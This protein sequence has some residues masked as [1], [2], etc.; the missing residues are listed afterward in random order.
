MKRLSK[1]IIE[2]VVLTVF[3]VAI[4]SNRPSNDVAIATEKIPTAGI[5]KALQCPKIEKAE[6]A[7]KIKKNERY[8]VQIA[9]EIAEKYVEIQGEITEH[10]A[11]LSKIEQNVP[12]WECGC[13]SATKTHM[14]YRAITSKCSPQ[15][16]L[17]QSAFTSDCGIRM[18]GNRY[19]VAVGTH[20]ADKVGQ[21][22]TVIMCS[23]EQIQCVVGDFKADSHTDES[24]RYHVG[25]YEN[26]KY[27]AGDGSVIEFIVDTSTYSTEKIPNEFDGAIWAIRAE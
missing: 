15:Y 27:Y 1:I 6:D 23:G 11:D 25:G 13:K 14:S 2:S 19:M 18:I 8:I 12:N 7:V 16:K 3:I 22:I 10:V 17:Q 24:H 5:C 21:E 26:G 4:A 20:Y 9:G